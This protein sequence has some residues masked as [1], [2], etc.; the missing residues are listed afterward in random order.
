MDTISEVEKLQAVQQLTSTLLPSST[1]NTMSNAED[2]CFQC[3]ELG[4]IAH[5]CPNIHCFECDD[6]GHIAADCL[7]RIP[8]SGTPAYHK[9]HHPAQGTAL[10]QPHDTT[11]ETVAGI[12]GQDHS[13]TLADI[14]ATVTTT[15]AEVI[16][17][18]INSCH[19]R[20]TL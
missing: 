9:R 13:C 10:G 18:H 15:H 7:D 3:Q 1:V 16:P 5:H 2:Q 12:V 20:R 17:G 6:F 4:H 14:A 8:P 11:T 19:H